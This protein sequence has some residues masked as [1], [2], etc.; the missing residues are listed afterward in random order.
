MLPHREP[1]ENTIMSTIG[2]VASSTPTIG[3]LAMVAPCKLSVE[4]DVF[5]A[6]TENLRLAQSPYGDRQFMSS[7][8]TTHN[9]DTAD[10]PTLRKRRR[11]S[12]VRQP[13]VRQT[14]HKQ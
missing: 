13:K 2:K 12:R 7:S 5:V 9:C 8:P 6:F 4:G 10:R 1:R 11:R 3:V 14:F